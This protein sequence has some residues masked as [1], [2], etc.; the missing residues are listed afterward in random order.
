LPII[1]FII[2]FIW[3]FPHFWSIAWVAD[4]DYTK[5]GFRLLP[6]RQKDRTSAVII[7]GATLAL[8]LAGLLPIFYGFG[9]LHAILSS[10]CRFIPEVQLGE[11]S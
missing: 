11:R 2:Q 6:T 1:L 10:I 5:A 3:L 9:G 8:L 4:E 7:L